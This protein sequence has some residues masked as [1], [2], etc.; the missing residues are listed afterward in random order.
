MVSESHTA[1]AEVRADTV[2]EVVLVTVRDTVWERV[3]ETLQ[4]NHTGDTLF[5]SVVTDRERIRNRER[6]AQ[7]KVKSEA[8]KVDTTSIVKENKTVAVA[9]GGGVEIDKDGN[10]TKKDT[11]FRST[12]KWVFAVIC[13][14]IG[15]IITVKICWRRA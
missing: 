12:L 14:A 15:F 6:D 10:L 3:T 13:A 4:L 2:R 5:R 1:R 11:P 9:A 7:L 8:L